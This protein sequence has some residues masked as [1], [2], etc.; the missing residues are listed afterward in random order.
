MS[1]A[2]STTARSKP[3][4]RRCNS[5]ATP[6]ELPIPGRLATGNSVLNPC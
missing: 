5:E 6:P 1:G 3:I 2:S 4:A